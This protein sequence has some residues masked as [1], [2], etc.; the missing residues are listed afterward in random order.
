[1]NPAA[2]KT[3]LRDL[4][5]GGTLIV[6]S[7]A[8][9]E[10]NLEKA[11]YASNPLE[12]GSLDEFHVHDVALTTMT[13]EALKEIDVTKREAER[14]KNMFALGPDVLALPPPDRRRRSRSS[15]ASSPD[16]GDRRGERQGVQGRLGLRRDERGLRGHLRGQA[17]EDSRP[18]PTATSPATRRSRSGSWRRASQRSCR[19]SS[20]PTRSR[21]PPPS[22]R[23]S[24]GYKHF[25]IRTFQAEDEIAAVG[26]AL[27]AAFGGSL[28]VSTS[29][30]PGVVLKVET[31]GLAVA[32]ELPLV[33]LD[34]Q[35]AG[36]STGMPT[37]PEQADLL[38]RACSAATPSRRCR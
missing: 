7:D 32:L 27:G 3:N 12:D 4:P 10:R 14:S 20:A 24:R 25:G 22:S 35:R 30:G 21:P 34:I 36:P 26:A 28:G 18:A 37:K 11:G 9:T 5:K 23:S 1:M 16:A 29:S 8:F 6:N 13:I 33:I 2:L 38:H 15:S 17:R 31:I 19:S